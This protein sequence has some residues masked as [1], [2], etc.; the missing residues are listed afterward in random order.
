M[1]V[2]LPHLGQ[3]KDQLRELSEKNNLKVAGT[4]G[5]GEADVF[6]VSN[7][8]TLGLSE[9]Q[10]VQS[11]YDGVKAMID[12]EKAMRPAQAVQEVVTEMKEVGENLM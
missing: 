4:F 3:D 12:A 10:I 8:R 9:V 6:D 2:H 11:L 1:H 5:V 7:N